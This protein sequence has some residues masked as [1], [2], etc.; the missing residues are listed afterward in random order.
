MM[1]WASLTVFL[2][3]NSLGQSS[4]AEKN[5][6]LEDSFEWHGGDAANARLDGL[7]A[8]LAKRPNSLGVIFI[9][10]GRKCFY[11]EPEAHFVGIQ[12]AMTFRRY[13]FASVKLIFAGFRDHPTTEFWVVP[14]GTS[15]PLPAP[16]LGTDKVQFIHTRSKIRRPYWCC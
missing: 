2:P 14:A 1:F 16:T 15:T 8:E 9:Y 6:Y 7:M 3:L 12:E 13:N 11:G 5:A 4:S 10:C